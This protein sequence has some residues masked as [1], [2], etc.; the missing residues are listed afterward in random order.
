MKRHVR[1]ALNACMVWVAVLAASPAQGASLEQVRELA[2]QARYPEAR[3]AFDRLPS[4]LRAGL[5]ARLLDGVLRVREGFPD[6]AIEVFA[7]I[8]RTHPNRPEPRINLALLDAARWGI[9]DIRERLVDAAPEDPGG[10]TAWWRLR[11]LYLRLALHAYLHADTIAPG[12]SAEEVPPGPP[13]PALAPFRMPFETPSPDGAATPPAGE[14]HSAPDA[15]GHDAGGQ[16]LAPGE[17][18]APGPDLAGAKVLG[19]VAPAGEAPTADPSETAGAVPDPAAL[20]TAD[21]LPARD[22]SQETP[23]RALAFGGTA[24]P[25]PDPAEVTVF[26]PGALAGKTPAP[27]PAQAAGAVPGLP[28]LGAGGAPSARDAARANEAAMRATGAYLEAVGDGL[29]T[30][31]AGGGQSRGRPGKRRRRAPPRV[32]TPPPGT[33]C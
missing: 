31:S 7:D 5:D 11:D 27:D 28:E 10:A 19:P 24:A 33:R 13:A 3:A 4:E 29:T 12:G 14:T 30:V 1:L 6:E 8:V 15:P 2:Q 25:D 26:E 20:D 17:T 22:A 9:P 23:E 21:P 16:A 18:R 32:R